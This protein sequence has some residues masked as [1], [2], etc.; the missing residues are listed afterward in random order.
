MKKLLYSSVIF[1]TFMACNQPKKSTST[2]ESVIMNSNKT[3]GIFENQINIGNPEN[4]GTV[5]YNPE[6]QS[7]NLT[8]SGIN[9]WAENDQFQYVYKLDKISYYN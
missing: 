8:G 2:N 4:I 6:D 5:N 9:M 3:F 1:I 7:Y